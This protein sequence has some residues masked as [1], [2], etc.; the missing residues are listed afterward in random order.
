MEH[1][2]DRIRRMEFYFDTLQEAARQVP[3]TLYAAGPVRDMLEC[4]LEYYEN[5]QWLQD[6]RCDERGELPAGLKR[7][8]LS[9]DGVYNF[10]SEI[11]KDGST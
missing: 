2:I 9:E 11:Q 7:G 3:E 5:G 1:R 4:L 8:V 6:Y 10:L